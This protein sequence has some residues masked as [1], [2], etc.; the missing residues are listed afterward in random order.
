MCDMHDMYRLETNMPEVYGRCYLPYSVL[1]AG[2]PSL[3]AGSFGRVRPTCKDCTD[4]VKGC[5][6]VERS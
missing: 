5:R 1:R 6:Y 4:V 2:P 3:A